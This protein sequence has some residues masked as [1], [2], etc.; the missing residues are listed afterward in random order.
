MPWKHRERLERLV[1]DHGSYSDHFPVLSPTS[2]VPHNGALIVLTGILLLLS[3][4]FLFLHP[5]SRL[6]LGTLQ[7]FSYI[8]PFHKPPDFIRLSVFHGGTLYQSASCKTY[9]LEQLTLQGTPCQLSLL[10]G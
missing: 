9:S 2:Y 3:L 1:L 5:L 10:E 7:C 8:Q 4:L 6:S